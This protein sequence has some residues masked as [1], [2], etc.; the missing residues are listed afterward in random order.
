MVELLS[1]IP[2]NLE[3]FSIYPH[4]THYFYL[5]KIFVWSFIEH[6]QVLVIGSLDL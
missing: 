5:W 2:T 6:F 1:N 3:N 4:F